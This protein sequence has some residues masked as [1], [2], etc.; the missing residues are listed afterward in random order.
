MYKLSLLF[1][2]KQIT[3]AIKT[4]T[5]LI[6]WLDMKTFLFVLRN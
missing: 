1:L 3:V 6:S 4:K 2:N 5:H